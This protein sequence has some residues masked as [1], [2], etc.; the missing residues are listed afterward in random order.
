MPFETAGFVSEIRE[1]PRPPL[2]YAL[3]ELPEKVLPKAGTKA[4]FVAARKVSD[5]LFVR[6]TLFLKG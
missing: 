4:S 1:V 3:N 2:G 5:H 6:T